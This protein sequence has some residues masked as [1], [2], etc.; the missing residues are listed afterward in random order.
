MYNYIY[1]YNV[2]TTDAQANLYGVHTHTH[3]QCCSVLAY[4]GPINLLCHAHHTVH[5]CGVE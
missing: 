4:N 1:I 2:H 3:I 5:T